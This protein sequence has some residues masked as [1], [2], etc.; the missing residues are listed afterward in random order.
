[1]GAS[2]PNIFETIGIVRAGESCLFK[3]R[4][5]A[6]NERDVQYLRPGTDLQPR[7]MPG[8]KHFRLPAPN[9]ETS[10]SFQQK[11][12]RQTPCLSGLDSSGLGSG[13]ESKLPPI[14]RYAPPAS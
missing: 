8:M 11:L 12:A 2:K 7:R 10:V 9:K 13:C 5:P 6:G 3:P 1:M 4:K 14:G